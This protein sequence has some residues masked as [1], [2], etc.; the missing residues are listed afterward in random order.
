M[1]KVT[2]VAHDGRRFPV[3]IA[4]GMTAREAALFNDVPGIDG[5]CGGQ[6]ACAT[7]HVHVDPTWIDRVG[8]LSDGSMEADLL[9][10]AEG[11]T[12][13][14]RLACQITLDDRL[15]GLLLHVPEQQY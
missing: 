4:S 1:V 5:D 7:C 11:T 15:D 14:S 8:C 12:E 3:E 10:F 2:F 13:E 9:Q 6:C